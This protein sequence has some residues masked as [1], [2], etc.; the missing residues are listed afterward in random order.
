[1]EYL[2]YLQKMYVNKTINQFNLLTQK[3]LQK[4]SI[5][6]ILLFKTVWLRVININ[7][8]VK[9]TL[10]PSLLALVSLINQTTSVKRMKTLMVLPILMLLHVQLLQKV[11]VNSLSSKMRKKMRMGILSMLS[12]VHVV[13]MA[14]KVKVEHIMQ[15]T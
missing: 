8:A 13:L 9:F 5:W 7:S 1:M 10:V 11:H 6:L 2:F 4:Q 12:D 14:M 3:K 15:N